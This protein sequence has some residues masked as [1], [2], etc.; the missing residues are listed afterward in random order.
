MCFFF[1]FWDVRR[2]GRMGHASHRWLPLAPVQQVCTFEGRKLTGHGNGRLVVHQGS[3]HG[4][5]AWPRTGKGIYCRGGVGTLVTM[6]VWAYA[7]SSMR[8]R[9]D[10][11]SVS[12]PFH[13]PTPSCLC[14]HGV[15]LALGLLFYG[16]IFFCFSKKKPFSKFTHPLRIVIERDYD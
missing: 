3:W 7:T 16:Q 8:K 4:R 6:T 5:R 13:G 9:M 15:T 12:L 14:R 11:D 1:S 10:N 2:R